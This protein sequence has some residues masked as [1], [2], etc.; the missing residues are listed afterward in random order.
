LFKLIV[1]QLGVIARVKLGLAQ[2]LLLVLLAVIS[3][4]PQQAL[5]RLL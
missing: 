2:W 1:N 5:Q 3:R 4:L